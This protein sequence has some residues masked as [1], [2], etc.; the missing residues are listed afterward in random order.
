MFLGFVSVLLGWTLLQWAIP[1]ARLYEYSEHYTWAEL[2][3]IQI[4]LQL[5]LFAGIYFVLQ[6][7]SNEWRQRKQQD[8]PLPKPLTVANWLYTVAPFVLVP[9][10]FNLLGAFMA[11]VSGVPTPF[12]HPDFISADSLDRA[13]T[14]WDF[15]FKN[16]DI[17]L[18]GT[19][20]P[21]AARDWHTPWFTGSLVLSYYSYYLTALVAALPPL[22]KGKWPQTRR[23]VA[24]YVGC[25]LSTYVGYVLFPSTGPR[26]EGGF[27]A[28][29]PE[30]S[31]WFF[32]DTLQTIL[33]DAEIIRWDAFPSGHT[34]VTL[35]AIGI[36]LRYHRRVGLLYLPFGLGLI[37]STVILGYHFAGD[38]I[39]GVAF[40]LI[41]FLV[42]DPFV[43]WW[44]APRWPQADDADRSAAP[45]TP[46]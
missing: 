42:L 12:D 45:E 4:A 13:A 18:F 24:V 19:Y 25:L 10:T 46:A 14:Y 1:S 3:H 15:T 33:N 27:E 8:A 41:A 2:P 31:S 38:V 39:A 23:F 16:M 7:L 22:L 43:R 35:V 11:T 26:F 32:G 28:W 5:A 17:A 6:R 9:L 21:E 44:D 40:T 20:P 29:L 34:A 37:A 30:Q 36:A